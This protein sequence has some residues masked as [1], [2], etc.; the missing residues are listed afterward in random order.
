MSW[1]QIRSSITF[2]NPSL[3]LSEY[4]IFELQFPPSFLF[5]NQL[6]NQILDG[7]EYLY[8]NSQTAKL[9]LDEYFVDNEMILKILPSNFGSNHK[10]NFGGGF[11]ELIFID[12]DDAQK[13]LLSLNGKLE[14]ISLRTI[15][16][17]EFLHVFE[18]F[19]GATV[20]EVETTGINLQDPGFDN[21]GSVVRMT[22]QVRKEINEPQR[23]AYQ[24]IDSGS[25]VSEY[26]QSLSDFIAGEYDQS[27]VLGRETSDLDET[28][29]FTTEQRTVNGAPSKDLLI[30]GPGKNDI[31]TG[32]GSDTI[33]GYFDADVITSGPGDD[34][35]WARAGKDQING[36]S[37]NDIINGGAGQ[38]TA[39]YRNTI[40]N[41][42]PVPGP[43][44]GDA[45][46]FL[47][48]DITNGEQ[49]KLVDIEHLRFADWEGSVQKYLAWWRSED[50]PSDIDAGTDADAEPTYQL[51]GTTWN[52]TG[53]DRRDTTWDG[54]SL[55]FTAQSVGSGE[56]ALEGHFNWV[57]SGGS[58]GREYFQGSLGDDGALDLRGVRLEDYSGIAKAVYDGELSDDGTRFTGN[59][60]VPSRRRFV[61]NTCDRS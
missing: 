11:S 6:K 18:Q 32:G 16:F 22:N 49:D 26:V 24:L 10:V 53:T 50:G 56:S 13:Q 36:G 33:V 37:G 52:V 8:Q 9:A 12:P 19:N 48:R 46:G 35:T 57:G 31:R 44:Q 17:H 28:V 5:S 30:G 20:P 58:Y 55:V 23:G 47:L 2:A 7:F 43:V 54:S 4:S 29:I 40:K 1:N 60:P 15:V 38:D 45:G 41:F 59:W 14:S 34:K 25:Q 21:L 61:A 3:N 39:I 51:A 42:A 27:I